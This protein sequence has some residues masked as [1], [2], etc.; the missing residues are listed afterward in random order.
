MD[1][2][3]VSDPDKSDESRL[4]ITTDVAAHCC[5]SYPNPRSKFDL[6]QA[7]LAKQRCETLSKCGRFLH[8]VMLPEW[9][10]KSTGPRRNPHTQNSRT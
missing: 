3:F 2:K 7:P 5:A 6:S 10:Q 4:A 1:P 9:Q 8:A